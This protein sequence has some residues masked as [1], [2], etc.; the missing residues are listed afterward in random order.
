M[1]AFNDETVAAAMLL[2]TEPTKER[3]E[4]SILC[5][6]AIEIYRSTSF[7]L[8]SLLWINVIFRE[9]P[10]HKIKTSELIPSV[11]VNM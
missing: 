5:T 1:P 6:A 7:T 2:R 3:V 10:R 8:L 11:E 9:S 4:P